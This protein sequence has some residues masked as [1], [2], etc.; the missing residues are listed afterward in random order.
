M[1]NR[2][3]AAVLAAVLVGVIAVAGASAQTPQTTFSGLDQTWLRT[4]AQSDLAEIQGGKMA[5]AKTQSA[6]IQQLAKRLV[7]DHTKALAM[8]RKLAASLKI[9]LPT[10]PAPSSQWELQVVGSFTGTQ[11]DRWYSTMEVRDHQQNIAET[12]GEVSLGQNAQVRL[13]ARKV[14][15]VLKMHLLMAQK[16]AR[17]A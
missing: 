15:A 8:K 1:K 4:A 10:T 2:I 17:A 6:S 9:K 7:T 5:M 14:L 12:A 3:L 11:F 16:A 13:L